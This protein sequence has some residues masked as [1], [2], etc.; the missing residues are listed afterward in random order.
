MSLHFSKAVT[1]I[2]DPKSVLSIGQGGV[3][4]GLDARGDVLVAEAEGT[5]GASS[6]GGAGA[7]VAVF[8]ELLTGVAAKAGVS[9]VWKSNNAIVKKQLSLATG[10]W[11]A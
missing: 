9:S 8:L 7:V 10:I 5:E 2:T 1:R 4:V 11:F 6:V 3:T